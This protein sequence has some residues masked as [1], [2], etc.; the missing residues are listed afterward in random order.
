[1]YSRVSGI[2]GGRQKMR[3]YLPCMAVGTCS[4]GISGETGIE[5]IYAHKAAAWKMA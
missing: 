3:G 4:E 1:M 2:S 5:A